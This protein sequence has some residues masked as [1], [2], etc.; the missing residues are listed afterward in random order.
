M[1][2]LR[3][4]VSEYPLQSVV[5]IFAI[6]LASIAEGFGISVLVPLINIIV[7][8]QSFQGDSAVSGFFTSIESALR[9][10]MA[11]I[12]MGPTVALL[13]G[14]F[15]AC[16]IVKCL[17]ILLADKQV[18]YTIAHISTDLRLKLLDA[19]FK[20]R[21]EYFLRQP[22]GKLTNAVSSEAN[23]AAQAF[24]FATKL[25]SV[26][27][28]SLIYVILA[29]LVSWKATLMALVVGALVIL[30]LRRLIRKTR[31][32]GQRQTE[33]L[34][35][36]ISRMT[37]S[38]RS[39]KPLKAM[40]REHSMDSLLKT[41]TSKLN[42]VL[43]KQVLSVAA[44]AAFQE[45][46]LI[47][48]LALT[49]Y[50]TLVHFSMSLGT[51]MAIVYLIRRV[52]KNIQKAQREYQH[53]VRCESAY[54]SLKEK[55]V[56]AGEKQEPRL[57]D[58]PATLEK[59]IRLVLVS[60]AYEE[61]LVLDDVSLVLPA[62]LFVALL[63]PS[64]AG[65]TTVADLIIG[66]LRPSKG[67]VWI[68]QL[69]LAETDIRSWRSMIGYVPQDTLLL[70]DSVYVNVT[71]GD[72][73]ISEKEVEEALRAA[74]AWH[75]VCDLTK[76]M[77]TILGEHGSTI[78]GGQRQRVAIARALVKRPKLLILDEATTALDPETETAI[79]RT[80]QELSGEV[81]ILSISHQ[82]A[83]L[84]ASAVAYRLEDGRV[85]LI[86][87]AELVD[88]MAQKLKDAGGLQGRK[89]VSAS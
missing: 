75:F 48:F 19:L 82:P 24:N 59:A 88:S 83:M 40:A 65:K 86:K 51:I 26:V 8:E 61:D 89:L 15:V 35:E 74:G 68:D 62:G 22:A 3:T 72:T 4:F 73:R 7:G 12:G 46:I 69:P 84:E 31:R 77:H 52:L 17:L 28:E 41:N 43:R 58:R 85:A 87:G 25:A 45:P 38:L 55:I 47:V 16:S 10:L 78:S 39:I 81:T 30:V 60:F 2:L 54:W 64:G 21:W 9:E 20:T 71:L 27:L 23:R 63:G 42:R 79:C 34:Q 14:V 11:S 44:L 36:L 18:G 53:M 6:L 32:D 80:L 49:L 67:E 1:R 29:V 76:G 70:H 33:L 56:E 5:T 37:D 66:L 57:G 13:L 50:V